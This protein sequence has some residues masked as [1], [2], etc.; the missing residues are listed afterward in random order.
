MSI[1]TRAF[2]TPL[3]G[4][5]IRCSDV[6][7]GMPSIKALNQDNRLPNLALCIEVYNALHC[8]I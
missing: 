1:E 8:C 3:F 6:R 5:Q 2:S 7:C 4:L